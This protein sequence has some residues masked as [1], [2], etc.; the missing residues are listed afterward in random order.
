M[1]LF[2][3]TWRED[4]NFHFGKCAQRRIRRCRGTGKGEF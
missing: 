4:I 3:G 2:G 1:R